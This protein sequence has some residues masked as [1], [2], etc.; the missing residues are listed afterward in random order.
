MFQFVQ[1]H[2]EFADCHEELCKANNPPGKNSEVF[3]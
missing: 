1:K 3:D 2:G